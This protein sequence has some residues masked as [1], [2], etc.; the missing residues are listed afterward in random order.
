MGF[1]RQWY[2]VFY[3]RCRSRSICAGNGCPTGKHRVVSGTIA[4]AAA[5][6][7]SAA[8]R[9]ATLRGVCPFSRAAHAPLA[10]E[11]VQ[12]TFDKPVFTVNTNVSLLT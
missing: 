7:G 9:H 12:S 1:F 2:I 8:K 11:P 4:D 5:G 6:V 3:P 10:H